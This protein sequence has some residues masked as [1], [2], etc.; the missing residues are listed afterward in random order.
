MKKGD[1]VVAGGIIAELAEEYV[2]FS[3]EINGSSSA[4]YKARESARLDGIWYTMHRLGLGD[5]F[6]KFVNEALGITE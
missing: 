2:Y 6:A 3:G 5:E 4:K 1:R